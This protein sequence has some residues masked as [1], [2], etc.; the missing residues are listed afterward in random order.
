MIS[1]VVPVYNASQY[2]G[3]CIESIIAQSYKNWELLIVNDGS[4][5]E[6]EYVLEAYL[7]NEKIKY[8]KQSNLGVSFARNFGISQ[9][10]GEFICFYRCR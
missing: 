1:V 4:T 6:T 8:F 9:A 7:D 3:N 2:I 10:K 5:D